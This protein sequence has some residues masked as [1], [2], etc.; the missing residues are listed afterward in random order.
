MKLLRLSSDEIT[1]D[2]KVNLN[3]PIILKPNSK[4]ALSDISI[5]Q[6]IDDI[7]I[8]NTND[9]ITY[10]LM[11]GYQRNAYIPN[12][13]YTNTT[14]VDMVEKTETALNNSLTFNYGSETISY[15]RNKVIGGEFSLSLN[16]QKINIEYKQSKTDFNGDIAKFSNENT[17]NAVV[18]EIVSGSYSLMSNI[19][20]ADLTQ[21]VKW[22]TY[23]SRGYAI[24]RCKLKSWT[25]T[26]A[27][28]GGFIIGLSETNL[29]EVKNSELSM[30]HVNYG[31]QMTNISSITK[32]KT[33]VNGIAGINNV[34][35]PNYVAFNNN[36]NDYIEVAIN[37]DKV[38]LNIYQYTT[39]W[40]KYTL[41]SF[42]Y[43]QKKLYPFIALMSDRNNLQ[44]KLVRNTLSPFSGSGLVENDN[45]ELLDKNNVLPPTGTK[46]LKSVFKIN[47]N[48]QSLSD[49]FGYQYI[50]YISNY[51]KYVKISGDNRIILTNIVEN[52]LIQLLNYNIDSYDSVKHGRCNVIANIPNLN[53][54]GSINMKIE[55][56][57]FIDLNN[58]DIL[59]LKNLHFRVL[60]GSYSSIRLEGQG[61][62][63]LLFKQD[64]EM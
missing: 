44:L 58:K 63:V 62:I 42:T 19:A 21:N 20:V 56:P 33:I 9:T 32:Y 37:G 6:S 7:V 47:F 2:F 64:G 3:D 22:D 30:N 39:V 34:I 53:E 12:D 41:E 14:I 50:S 45:E 35:T 60:D 13:I 55:N 57:I 11:E 43:N 25:D 1:A 16:D 28:G 31:I 52:Y 8:D 40:N 59:Y 15:T 54:N 29:N 18:Y 46:G 4:I 51:T 10:D 38:E 23:V 49:F 26:I 36:E 24:N 61:S 27:N 5:Q 48:T 17:A